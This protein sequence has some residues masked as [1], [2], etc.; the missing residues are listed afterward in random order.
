MSFILDRRIMSGTLG[1]SNRFAFY[2]LCPLISILSLHF[3]MASLILR[4]CV[5]LLSPPILFTRALRCSSHGAFTNWH[6]LSCHAATSVI[7]DCFRVHVVVVV[8]AIFSDLSCTLRRY[9]QNGSP[10][11]RAT[12][13]LASMLRRT[14]PLRFRRCHFV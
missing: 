3:F 6:I 4:I 9:F 12:S 2:D 7:I 5:R 14:I 8:A 10:S 1:H 11:T 13:S